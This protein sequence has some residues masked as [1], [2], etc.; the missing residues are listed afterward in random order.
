MRYSVTISG[1]DYELPGRTEE[2]DKTISR[3]TEIERLVS[4]GEITRQQSLREQYEFVSACIQAELPD[5]SEIDVG[6][7]E[8]A[9]L[10]II[11]AYSEPLIRAKIESMTGSIRS[12]VNK[13]E[14]KKLILLAEA[15]N[16]AQQ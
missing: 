15:S 12:I 5:F 2:M 8:V 4:K 6:D 7:L 16:K 13:P 10:E 1:K 14:I 9:R 3:M 11:N